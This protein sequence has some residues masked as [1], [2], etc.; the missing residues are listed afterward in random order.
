VPR[1]RIGPRRAGELAVEG[2]G[3]VGPVAELARDGGADAGERGPVGRLHARHHAEG[4]VARLAGERLLP[5]ERLIEDGREREHIGLHRDARVPHLVL[6]GRRVPEARPRERARPVEPHVGE[7]H[8]PEVGDLG[9][10]H[11][12]D[13]REQDV[14]RLEVA[15]DDAMVVDGLERARDLP[16]DAHDA[17][18]GE[19][20]AAVGADD[21]LERLSV[22]VLEDDE[23]ERHLTEHGV[24][25]VGAEVVEPD[26]VWISGREGP[27]HAEDIGLALKPG[28]GLFL[29]ALRA[30][31]LHDDPEAVLFFVV[32]F[33]DPALAALAEDLAQVVSNPGSTGERDPHEGVAQILAQIHRL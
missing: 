1:R 19:P 20:E 31:H 32:G 3:E 24:D 16:H 30:E 25:R 9:D 28:E 23:R 18:D 17:R 14:R 26:D 8:E 6:L 13:L 11:P 7:L 2:G 27:E 4:I 10:L 12:I 29:D 21:V 15:V 5:R 33:V 22:D